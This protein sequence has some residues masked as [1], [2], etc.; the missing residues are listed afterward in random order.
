MRKVFALPLIA[1]ALLIPAGWATAA[2]D[3]NGP[4]CADI[5]DSDWGYNGNPADPESGTTATVTLFVASASCPRVTY[6]LF[7]QDEATAGPAIATSGPVAG[8]GIADN[9][10]GPGTDSVTLIATVPT[11]ERDGTICLYATTSKSGRHDFDRAPDETLSPNCVPLIPGGSAG[12]SG[13]S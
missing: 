4:S 12:G 9:T 1:V 5:I 13:F 6:T 2:S 10:S 7:V 11:G 8:D 3:D